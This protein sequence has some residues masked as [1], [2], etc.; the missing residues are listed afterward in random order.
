MCNKFNTFMEIEVILEKIGLQRK[1]IIIYLGLLEHGHST[2]ADIARYTNLYRP[3]VYKTLPTLLDK[4]LVSKGPFGKRTMYMA[5]SP[6]KLESTLES[7]RIELQKAVPSLQNLYQTVGKR[8]VVKYFYSAKGI[9][10]VY[11]DLIVSLKKNNTYYRYSSTKDSVFEHSE[12]LPVNY[13]Q[14]QQRKELDR[15]LITSERRSKTIPK[16]ENLDF[17]VIPESYDPFDDNIVHLI[18]GNKVAFIDY[19]SETAVIIE[20]KRFADFQKKLFLLLYRKL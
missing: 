17:K 15:L 3:Y 18:Y 6:E 12:Y 13:H 9:R 10:A 5:E 1:E 4:G 14:E 2:V 20:S 19:D 7:T 16:K 8:P 11:E